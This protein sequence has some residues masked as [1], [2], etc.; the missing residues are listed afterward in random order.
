MA[1]SDSFMQAHKNLITVVA[2]GLIGLMR[3]FAA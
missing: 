2:F 1:W 3:T